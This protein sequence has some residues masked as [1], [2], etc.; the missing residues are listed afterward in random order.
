MG[1]GEGEGAS[2]E[3][4][5]GSTA[6]SIVDSGLG[7]GSRSECPS[8]GQQRPAAACTSAREHAAV[9]TLHMVY[10]RASATV[11]GREQRAM[12]SA[13]VLCRR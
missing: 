13:V 4:Q 5:S 8:S 6:T 1:E 12:L 9:S 7:D 10:A 2:Q 3:I 11:C